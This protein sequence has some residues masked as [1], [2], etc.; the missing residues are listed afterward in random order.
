VICPKNQNIRD[1]YVFI[2][3]LALQ[4]APTLYVLNPASS[5]KMDIEQKENVSYSMRVAQS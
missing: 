4:F 1:Y 2:K 5:V 3:N